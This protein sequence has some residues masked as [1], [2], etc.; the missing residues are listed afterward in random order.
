M[1][2]ELQVEMNLFP[3]KEAEIEGIQMGVLSDGS[4]YLTA[5]GLARMCGVD[6][7]VIVRLANNW[8]DEQSKPR[9]V[10]IRELLVTQ[11]YSSEH[12]YRRT[13]GAS[14][15]THAYTDAV[16][17]ALLE[18]YAFEAQQAISA[19]ALKNF[20]LLARQSFRS[21]IYAKVGYNPQQQIPQSW[22]NF[23]ERI[24]LNDTI[25]VNY[26][27]VF[28][29]MADMVIHL[30]RAGFPIDSHCVPDISVGL[31]WAKYWADNGLAAGYGER[32][33]HPHV[34]PD[35]FPQSAA[36]PIAAWIYPVQSLGAF[37]VWLNNHYLLKAFPKYLAA[38]VS[39][40]VLPPA[41]AELLIETVTKKGT[42]Q[43]SE[44]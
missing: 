18:Y 14:G 4:P 19:T 34:Y 43:I 42:V 22:K 13:Q 23:Q 44:N 29:E 24:L 32:V 27:S 40:G 12:L 31:H 1:A 3:I 38:K 37:R 26:Y 11:G 39:S 16:C 17:M 30:I 5:R 2:N 10:K 15:E 35:W 25:P 41:K 36:G 33:K 6:H 7:T 28:R 21:F 9:G 8:E 20:R